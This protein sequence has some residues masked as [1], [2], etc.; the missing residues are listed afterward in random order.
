MNWHAHFGKN[1]AEM[2]SASS[3]ILGRQ[4]ES[5]QHGAAANL[6]GQDTEQCPHDQKVAPTMS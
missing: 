4:A 1:K 2:D 6:R 3:Q 5:L